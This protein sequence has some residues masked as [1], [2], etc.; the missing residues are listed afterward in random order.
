M[1]NASFQKKGRVLR[2]PEVFNRTGLSP[3]T[4]NRMERAGKFPRRIQISTL[5]VGWVEAEVENWIME[6]AKARP[7]EGA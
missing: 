2:K 6:R 4:L 7:G 1:E 5:C 3:S